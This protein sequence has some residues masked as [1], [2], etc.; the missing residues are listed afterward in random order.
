MLEDTRKMLNLRKMY[1]DLIYATRTA[2]HAPIQPLDFTSSTNEKIPT[3]YLYYN[4]ERALL[5][6]ANPY[7][8]DVELQ[9]EIPIR[10]IWEKPADKLILKDVWGN[11]RHIEDIPS[12]GNIKIKIR[13]DHIYRGGLAVWEISRK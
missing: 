9:I 6:A 12:N 11:K 3:P 10:D 1:S 2:T 13:K 8:Y 5:V 4:N 7:D